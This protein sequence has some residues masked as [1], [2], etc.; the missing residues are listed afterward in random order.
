MKNNLQRA[1][2]IENR[3]NDLSQFSDDK[4]HLKRIFGSKA[5]LECSHTIETW[6]REAGLETSVDAIGNIRGR[7]SSTHPNAK[8]FVIA[9]H[10]D[11]A[12]NSGRYDGTLGIIMGI[13]VIENI[14]AQGIS[15]PFH[16]EVIAFSEEEGV[17]FQSAYLKNQV[18]VDIRNSEWPET[19]KTQPNALLKDLQPL[20]HAVLKKDIFNLRDW[21]GYFE[22]HI[23]EGT[24][25]YDKK[26]PVGVVNAIVGQ[27][28]IEI[29]FI[30]E[31]GHAGT[32]PMNQR[33]DALSAAAKFILSVEK[34]AFKEKK[35]ILATVGKLE[36]QDAAANLIPGRVSCTVDIR[37]EDSKLLS[38]AYE[39]I[40]ELCEK[41]CDKRNIYFEWKLKH[42]IEPVNCSKKFRKLLSS[43]IEEKHLEVINLVCG[44]GHDAASVSQVAPVGMLF[45]KC[46]KDLNHHPLATVEIKDIATALDVADRFILL[47]S[48]MAEKNIKKKFSEN[49]G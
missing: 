4:Y 14:K 41:I 2:K 29:T 10:Y 44:S 37:S 46:L 22:I 19:R 47:I 12:I 5:F 26:I 48:E 40:N 23:D 1:F 38:D 3:I 11:T 17:R 31:S 34:Y 9:S 39:I 42:E 8:T 13:D 43:A 28:R 18:M 27:K 35:N 45:V 6:M 24:T 7:L 25:L 20:N 36:I 33:R 49:E 32:V 16:I 30:G 21:L 15:L